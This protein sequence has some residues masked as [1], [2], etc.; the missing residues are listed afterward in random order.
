M[1]DQ[2]EDLIREIAAKHGIAVSRDD[3]ILVLQTINSRLMLDSSAAHQVQLNHFKEELELISMRWRTDAKDKA[4]RILNAA[5][6]A[7]KE[8]MHASVMQSAEAASERVRS[9][10][11]ESLARAES[12]AS[13]AN[14]SAIL[15]VAASCITMLAGTILLFTWFR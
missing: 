3:P 12:A 15:N 1:A 5:L 4:D 8:A 13:M 11:N 9:A 10:M 2:I 6:S 14:R 7:S